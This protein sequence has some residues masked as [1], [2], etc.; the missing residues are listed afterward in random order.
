MPQVNDDPRG[1]E[2][3][4]F[5]GAGVDLARNRSK[6]RMPNLVESVGTDGR[7]LGAIR[8]FPGFADSSVHGIPA[9]TLT[10][11]RLAK[12]VAIRKGLGNGVLRGIVYLADNTE[13]KRING[14]ATTYRWNAST[15][16]TYTDSYYLTYSL[17]SAANGATPTVFYDAHVPIPVSMKLVIDG[18]E[19]TRTGT[20]PGTPLTAGQ[21]GVHTTALAADIG[22]DELTGDT[23]T[24]YYRP[25][26]AT[27]PDDVAAVAVSLRLPGWAVYFSYWDD[28][29]DTATT[30][31]LDDLR[32]LEGDPLGASLDE[33]DFACNGRYIYLVT[34]KRASR[35]YWYDFTYTSWQT[36]TE[37]LDNRYMGIYSPLPIE[38]YR[39]TDGTTYALNVEGRQATTLPAEI[40]DGRYWGGVELV[41]RKHGTRSAL[42]VDFGDVSGAENILS[43][44]LAH[45]HMP[46]YGTSAPRKVDGR[47]LS[48]SVNYWGMQHWDSLRVWRR[49]KEDTSGLT[50]QDGEVYGTYFLEAEASYANNVYDSAYVDPLYG[51]TS[52]F[53]ELAFT[54]HNVA[55]W[56]IAGFA[57]DQALATTI[58]A[59]DPYLHDVG[60]VPESSRI[61]CLDGMTVIVARPF[62]FA[63][64]EKE[65]F[66][67]GT[68]SESIMY[69][70]L[71]MGE[72]ENFP[73]SN[74]W[75]PS[76]PG[77]IFH[78]L[79]NVGDYIAAIGS[80]GIHRLLQNGSELAGVTL[81][82]GTGGVG[83][84]GNAAVGSSL[85]FV[86]KAG[87]K[88][89]DMN[90]GS[91]RS[92]SAVD[93]MIFDER[94]WENSLASIHMAYDA[95][96]GALILL[97]TVAKECIILWESSGAV[98]T[99]EDC[100]WSFLTEGPD[101][102]TG[103]TQRAY[104][105]QD[106]GK[107]HCIDGGRDM[108]VKS[109]CGAGGGTDDVLVNGT[110]AAS[111]TTTVINVTA[112]GTND[113]PDQLV[114]FKVYFR[115][116]QNDGLSRYVSVRNGDLQF[117]VS[118][119]LPY[120]PA[121]GDKISLAPI[122]F[123]VVCPQVR[124]SGGAYD[125]FERKKLNQIAPALEAITGGEGDGTMIVGA[126][127]RTTKLDGV[128][129][130]YNV[131]PDQCW[132]Q[133][134]ANGTQLYPYVEST[135]ADLDFELQALLT[136]VGLTGSESE[137][138]QG[139]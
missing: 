24:I 61:A 116:G 9:A 60:R 89:V 53:A 110:V 35:A 38:K 139:S 68:L 26:V 72:V 62:V 31:Q 28:D 135:M 52:N 106:N 124:G 85:F 120:A 101:P 64:T 138:R 67:T 14:A 63:D 77:E 37:G 99:L 127:R 93:R 97:N 65:W 104:F 113:I 19:T 55:A 91:I 49:L 96:V 66:Y 12:Y 57:P 42:Y 71:V 33:Y 39:V 137:S 56:D 16:A 1:R 23:S 54:M 75:R 18:V 13:D 131:V 41:S 92:L 8:P 25:A 10:N 47:W 94:E 36:S 103:G 86:S 112:N 128:D 70:S 76:Q 108:P 87:L 115:S 132:G 2:I 125:S 5:D 121:S 46:Q 82:R 80:G 111:S 107:V 21:W 78:A 90:T 95:T 73:V 81:V 3:F 27:D 50:G 22:A 109:M 83:R 43:Y 20:F 7:F 44:S 122:R 118:E 17:K 69:S 126:Y 59:Y 51:I 134:G 6:V 15:E 133:V 30:V 34:G 102:K 45:Y 123:R 136:R 130:G 100:P 4:E 32:M 98:T 74:V 119:A 88:E 58:N 105:I 48:P 11:I 114:G 29:S 40:P 84:F 129:V 117:T 79:R